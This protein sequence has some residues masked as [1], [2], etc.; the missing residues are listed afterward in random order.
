[1]QRAYALE[2]KPTPRK[3]ASLQTS[4]KFAKAVNAITGLE[5]DEL[6][7][8]VAAIRDAEDPLV[9][10][11][12]V[13]K[14]SLPVSVLNYLLANHELPYFARRYLPHYF[15]T[16]LSVHMHIPMFD[17]LHDILASTARVPTLV[18]GWRE[19]GKSTV[20][21]RLGTIH[22]TV[23]PNIVYPDRFTAI[24]MAKEYV[25]FVSL[26]KGGARKALRA[27][28]AEF[29]DNEAIRHD[30]GEFYLVNGRKPMQWN[31]T[32][33]VTANGVYFEAMS[34]RTS[35]RGSLE[36]HRRPD[37][38]IVDDVEDMQRARNSADRRKEDMEW[39]TQEFIPAVSTTKGS[40]V[41][42]GN[43]GYDG[44]MAQQLAE[45]GKKNKW[46]VLEFRVKQVDDKGNEYYTWPK[47]FG[48]SFEKE[49]RSELVFDAA[50][51]T[52]YMLN[53]RS[54]SAEID[55]TSFE[56]YNLEHVMSTRL[57][58]CRIYF[59]C[60]PAISESRSADFTA[61]VPIAFDAP[62]GVKYV[63]P[64]FHKRGATIDEIVDAIIG[65][66]LR[67]FPRVADAGVEDIAFQRVIKDNVQSVAARKG[68]SISLRGVKQGGQGDKRMRIR[69][70]WAPIKRKEIL[71]LLEDPIHRVLIQEI[72]N[73]RSAHDDLADSFEMSDRIC[74][75]DLER[76]AS[77]KPRG[78]MVRIVGGGVKHRKAG[79]ANGSKAT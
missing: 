69:R 40:P 79:S 19:C 24:N 26:I 35:L 66:W 72:I 6:H 61:I 62:L 76:R 39:F 70:T 4:G 14:Y 33:F 77:E 68:V 51:E 63:L 29:E 42:L 38:P 34:R 1:M 78:A 71:F 64:A 13:C 74:V 49:K 59:V 22:A 12:E 16:E 44:C 18:A 37:F 43:Y 46:R 65:T 48:E 2:T 10:F 23:F 9:K 47:K 73:E 27:V 17:A 5:G 30:L 3:I 20:F 67:Y 75:E 57:P 55:S 8:T 28:Q 56:G 7:A 52:E 53:P 25:M 15:D 32:E 36:R 60:D 11:A 41:L 21:S 58:Y 45:W 54:A 31:K 50:W